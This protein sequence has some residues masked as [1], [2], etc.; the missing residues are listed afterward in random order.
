MKR[1]TVFKNLLAVSTLAGA[2]APASAAAKNPIQLHTDMHVK[3]EEEKQLLD[4]FHKLFLPRIRKAPGF[5]DAKLLKFTQANVG[6]PHPHYNYRLIQVF[7]TEERREAWRKTE[8]HKI[9]WHQAIESHLKIPFDALVYE[10]VA[11]SKTTRA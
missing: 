5:I 11:E 3:I 6:K 10:I 4:D 7:E 2:A 1:R 8:P 9:A